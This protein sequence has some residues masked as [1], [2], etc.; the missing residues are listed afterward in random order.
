METWPVGL[1]EVMFD[2]GILLAALWHLG[3]GRRHD[4]ERLARLR[5]ARASATQS[6][7]AERALPPEVR[8]GRA[9]SVESREP[10]RRLRA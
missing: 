3:W 9:A 5:Q 7:P 10:A 8:R 2:G 6:S 4:A 1:I